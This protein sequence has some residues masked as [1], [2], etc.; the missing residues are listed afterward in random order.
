MHVSF[1]KHEEYGTLQLLFDKC[2]YIPVPGRGRSRSGVKC[3]RAV[4]ARNLIYL[5]TRV[6]NSK[7]LSS[8]MK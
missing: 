2:P 5:A 4:F 7:L 8:E 3:E 6:L 1:I